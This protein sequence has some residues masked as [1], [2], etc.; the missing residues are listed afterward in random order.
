MAE[1]TIEGMH[2]EACAARVK[3][4]IETKA[5]GTSA[6]IDLKA[7]KASVAGVPAGVD[8]AAIITDAGY[9]ARALP[10]TG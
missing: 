8:I 4:V 7:A 2:C 5:P 3:R 10:T 9:P 1:F 6:S